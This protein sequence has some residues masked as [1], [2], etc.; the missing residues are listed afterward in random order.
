MAKDEASRIVVGVDGSASSNKAL[1]WAATQAEKTGAA[2]EIVTSWQWPQ[3]YGVPLPLT[4][5]FDPAAVAKQVNSAAFDLVRKDH[6]GVEVRSSIAE[7]HAGQVLTEMSADADML[8]V[9]SRGH[10]EIVGLLLGST[11]E[12]CVAHGQ[13]PVVVLH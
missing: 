9:G 4:E 7:G 2:L 12:Y 1:E 8:V 3:S 13:C 10:S 5:D 11:S 6:S